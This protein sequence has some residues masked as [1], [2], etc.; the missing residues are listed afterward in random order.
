MVHLTYVENRPTESVKKVVVLWARDSKVL[1]RVLH[2]PPLRLIGEY[3]DEK[4]EIFQYKSSY[5]DIIH[6][7]D[8]PRSLISRGTKVVR[9]EEFDEASGEWKSRIKMSRDK[10]DDRAKGIILDEY[11]K[12]GRIGESAFHAGVTA[13]RVRKEL[14]DDEDFGE[15]MLVAEEAYQDKLVNH[16]QNLIF[17]GTIKKV[18][19]RNGNLVSEETIYPIPLIQ[20]ELRRHIKGYREK[21]EV[22]VT[23]KGGVLIAPAETKTIEDWEKRFSGAKDITPSDPLLTDD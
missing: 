1:R 20:M 5:N 10:F 16:H 17:D 13:Q 12:W 14:E 8:R 4:D 7:M 9:I 18:Y 11:A 3:M 19:D 21:Q 22:S 6:G 2:L 15:A 23:H